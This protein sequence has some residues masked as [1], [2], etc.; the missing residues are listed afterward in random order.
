[1]QSELLLSEILKNLA[2]GLIVVDHE[3]N[4]LY[5]NEPAT[6]LAGIDE[7]EAVG[8][9]IL[10][11]FKDLTVETST[12]YQVLR[13]G[14]PIV[15]Y[16]QSYHN[17]EGRAITTITST[18]PLYEEGRLTGAFEIYR[19]S[20]ALYHLTEQMEKLM[21]KQT[22]DVMTLDQ[23]E[24]LFIGISEDIQNLRRCLR[25]VADSPSPV[26]IYGETGVG[27]ELVVQMIHRQSTKRSQKPLIAQ[28]CAAIPNTLL[29]SILFGTTVGSFT[30]AKN[31][32]GLFELA[33]GGILYLDEINSMDMELQAKLLRV[34]QD[35]EIRRIGAATT[36]KV[37][38]R[39][40]AS[41]NEDPE[42]LV[43]SGRLREDLYYRLKVIPVYIPPLRERTED[44]P[45][46]V[47]AFVQEFN[48]K[49]NKH[50]LQVDPKLMERLMILPWKGNVRELKYLI[51]GMMNFADGSVLSLEHYPEKRQKGVEGQ[52]KGLEATSG[53]FNKE[54]EAFEV[55]MIKEAMAAENCHLTKA[56]KRL[57]L[58]KQT[59]FNKMKKYKIEVVKKI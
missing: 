21:K 49:L 34:L 24:K 15:D 48:K 1:M 12:F 36:V 10:D 30:G 25:Q 8:K 58:P 40:V 28:N 47:N 23:E 3:A 5:F 14:K 52:L 56:A 13:T 55:Q 31:S 7:A 16:V 39:I 44:I 43:A 50:I 9:N 53:D 6:D 38:A 26:F 18:L 33:N 42:I 51:E 2:E 19:E 35:Q 27:K 22:V 11:V 29:E 57:G 59:L 45:I 4:I 17:Y 20:S 37:D 41:T 54:V 32:P 46:M